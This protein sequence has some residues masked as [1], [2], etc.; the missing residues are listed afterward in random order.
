MPSGNNDLSLVHELKE[1]CD[2][3]HNLSRQGRPNMDLMASRALVLIS[4]CIIRIPEDKEY[5]NIS[6]DFLKRLSEK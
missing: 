6:D 1:W 3:Y 5:G 2:D 4:M